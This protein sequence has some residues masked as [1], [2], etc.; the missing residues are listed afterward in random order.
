MQGALQFLFDLV[1]WV[2]V[3]VIIL[4]VLYFARAAAKRPG[5][6]KDASSIKSGFWAGFVL[7][8]IVLVY[9]VGQFLI[10]GFPKNGIYQG[11]NIW[12][13]F[14]TALGILLLLTVRHRISTSR[15][16]GLATLL[17]SFLGFYALADYLFIR[18]Y[19]VILLSATLGVA[20]GALLG[21]A[22]SPSSF[23]EFFTLRRR[24]Q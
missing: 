2:F 19:N 12:I 24:R 5:D 21:F 15:T 17:I 6:E 22:S 11:F 7:F 23:R 3:P 18:Q 1:I 9:K 13:V 16:T 10:H 20:F 4:T 14:G 8:L